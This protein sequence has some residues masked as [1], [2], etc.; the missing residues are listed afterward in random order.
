MKT[1]NEEEAEEIEKALLNLRNEKSA[2]AVDVFYKYYSEGDTRFANQ[3]GYIYSDRKF[4]G[5][6]LEKSSEF[7]SVLAFAGD[8]YAQHALGGIYREMGNLS[9][10]IEWIT[11]GSEGGRAECS[12][13]LYHHY[14]KSKDN[15]SAN[16]FLGKAVE[17]NHVLAVQR[18]AINSVLC[19]NGIWKVV[20]G[21][22]ML[23][24]NFRPVTKY[25]RNRVSKLGENA[26]PSSKSMS[27]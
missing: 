14:Q 27:R 23:V 2:L 16:Y 24:R 15:V 18:D 1:Y 19:R 22:I 26:A 12:Y 8:T 25:A 3:L 20:P 7:Y 13:V 10:S 11:K 9:K 4:V 17:Q 5:F 21:L 6:N